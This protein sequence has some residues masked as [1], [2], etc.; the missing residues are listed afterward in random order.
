MQRGT[1]VLAVLAVV[2]FTALAGCSDDSE[3]AGSSAAAGVPTENLNVVTAGTL[4]IG[5]DPTYPPMEFQEG[6]EFT[7][8]NVDM[9]TDLAA[10][11][12]LTPKF[13]EVAFG[14]LRP[15]LADHRID[16]AGASMTDTAERQEEVDFVDYFIAGSQVVATPQDVAGLET[17]ADWCGRTAAVAP[18]TVDE[19][20]VVAQSE[21][22]VKAGKQ[23][24]KILNVAY[25]VSQTEVLAGRADFGLEGMP[26]AARLVAQSGGKLAVAG[27]VAQLQPQ[28]YGYAVAKDRTELRTAVQLALQQAIADGTYDALLEKYE[29]SDGALRTTA[30]NGGA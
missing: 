24:V 13:V 12:G 20:A 25:G 14:D 17:G 19:D 28:P 9:T 30:I 4:T 11:L 3:P 6:G 1:R 26:V 7:G 27:K 23:P 21:V 8:F 29:V 5:I 2:S 15:S 22:C 18:D 16:L 10:R